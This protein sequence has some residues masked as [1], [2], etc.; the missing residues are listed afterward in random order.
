[1]AGL[2]RVRRKVQGRQDR[3]QEQPGAEVLAD[4]VGMLALP[5]QPGLFRQRLFQQGRGVHEHLQLPSETALQPAAELLQTALDELVIVVALGI[6]ADRA[7][8]GLCQDRQRITVRPVVHAEHDGRA[9]VLPHRLGMRPARG[10]LGQPVHLAVAPLGHEVGQ[11]V[12]GGPGL[13]RS[14]EAADVEAQ[15]QGP[16]ADQLFRTLRSRG[17]HSSWAAPAPA[18]GR[19]GAAESRGGTSA[20]CTR[21][22][23]PGSRARACRRNSR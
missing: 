19:P 7:L 17:R 4:Q 20:S 8:R 12:A 5:A 21:S 9:G 6:D 1:M 23:P 3:A 11:P 14:G 16:G 10:G 2:R 13:V 18:S 15:R 22:S